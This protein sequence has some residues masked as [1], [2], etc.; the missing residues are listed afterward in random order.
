MPFKLF[1]PTVPNYDMIQQKCGT[2]LDELK[3]LVFPKDY[4]PN[5]AIKRSAPSSSAAPKRAKPD[6]STIDVEAMAKAGK[7]SFC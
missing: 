4:D 5:K 6:P 3:D 7:V 2:F 1:F